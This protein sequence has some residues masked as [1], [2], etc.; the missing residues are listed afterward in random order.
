MDRGK[1][2]ADWEE[3]SHHIRFVRAG[4]RCEGSP[5]Y[6]TCRAEHGKPHP[7][8]GSKVVLT[9]AHLD[10]DPSNNDPGN[11]RAMCQRCH[12][13]HDAQQH[14]I[15]S[16]KTRRRKL[17]EAGQLEFA[18]EN[19]D[20]ERTDPFDRDGHGMDNSSSHRG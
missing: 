3:I 17:L 2:P 12:L 18:W 7:A 13:A 14:R 6:P 15:S 4:G 19:R 20:T 1:Y 5:V 9:V 10:H 16:A 8:T 11:L